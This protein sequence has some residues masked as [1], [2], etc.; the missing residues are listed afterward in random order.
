MVPNVFDVRLDEI[1]NK[2]A[3][4]C[5]RAGRNPA[6]ITIL[7]ASKKQP[8]EA[9][10]AVQAALSRRGRV[11]CFGE[12]YLQDFKKKKELLQAP[13]ISH[14]IGP[15]QSNKAKEAVRLFDII[16]SVHCDKV[17][18]ELNKAA[19]SI[20]KIQEIF[21]QINISNDPAKSGYLTEEADKAIEKICREYESLK[22]CGLMTITR[23]YE[24]SED[25]RADF[26]KMYQLKQRLDNK[27]RE[28]SCTNKPLEL[29]M[30]MSDDF[31]I[32]AEE[33]AT[34]VRIGT[35]LFGER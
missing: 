31:N 17:A 33:G 3:Q 20:G 11:V 1:E 22:L 25:V 16:E 29:S 6:Q 7:A 30:G 12:N 14:M 26:K 21:V 34:I 8:I 32:A 27:L 5:E 9:M 24:N 35:A 19:K 2:L 23:Y 13:F 18:Q 4:C 15:L 10:N 28:L